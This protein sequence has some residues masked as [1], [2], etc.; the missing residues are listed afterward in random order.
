MQKQVIVSAYSEIII[1]KLNPIPEREHSE[2]LEQGDP[3]LLPQMIDLVELGVNHSFSKGTFFATLYFQNIQNPIQRVN[4]IY[5]DTILNRVFTN[6]DR[7]RLFGIEMGTNFKLTLWYNLYFGANIYNYK[8]NGGLNVLGV[9]STVNNSNWV[10]SINMNNTF[11][12]GRSWNL[13]ANMNYLSARPT[14]QGEDSRFLS[15]NSSIKKTILNG[16]FSIGLQWQNMNLGFMN[17]N[18][19]RITTFGKNFYTTTN[20]IYETDVL[21]LNFSFNLNKLTNRPKLPT[22]EIGEKEF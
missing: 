3:D 12:L 1:F 17:T 6:V 18:Q 21:L 11:N 2:T 22:S 13:Q 5:A 10:Y 19:Q 15:V 16:K 9:T 14:A 4:S 7:A 8:I 20:Y